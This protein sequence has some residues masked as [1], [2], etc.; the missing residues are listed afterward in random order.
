VNAVEAVEPR[1][2]RGGGVVHALEARLSLED[3]FDLLGVQ[4]AAVCEHAEGF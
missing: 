1:T 4:V 3:D 2:I